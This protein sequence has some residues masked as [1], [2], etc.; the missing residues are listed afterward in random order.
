MSPLEAARTILRCEE[1]IG[2]KF[3]REQLHDGDLALHIKPEDYEDFPKVL[4][5]FLSRV[6]SLVRIR[7][8]YSK[9]KPS[10]QQ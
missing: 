10:C 4:T 9:A 8:Q 5:L 3:T 2:M 1:R 6:K 7:K